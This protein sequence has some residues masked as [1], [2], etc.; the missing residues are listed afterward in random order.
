MQNLSC[1][2]QEEYHLTT[3]ISVSSP[4]H[5]CWYAVELPQCSLP[6]YSL[7]LHGFKATDWVIYIVGWLVI[8]SNGLDAPGISRMNHFTVSNIYI[9]IYI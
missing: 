8:L 6:P 5:I 7:T 3:T 1:G 2:V 9:Y 4:A